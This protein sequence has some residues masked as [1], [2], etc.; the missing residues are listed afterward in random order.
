MLEVLRSKHLSLGPRVPAFEREFA[1][2]VG[3][4]HASRGL[5]RHRRA[6]PRAAR[7]GRAA[8]ATRSSRRR[9]ASSRPPT[10]SSTSARSPSSWTSTRAR[11]TSTS[12]PRRPRSPNDHRAAA[13]PHLRLPGRHARAGAARAADRR[14][15]LRGARR[16]VTPTASPSAAA[17]TPRRSAST[18]TSSSSPARAGCSRTGSGGDQGARGLRAQPGP[19]ARHGLAGPRPARLQ[20]PADRHGVRD[21]PGPAAA[22]RRHA[23]RPRPGGG[24][25]PR[26]AGRLRGPGAAV[27]GH[28]RTCAAGSCSSSSSRTAPTATRRSWRWRPTRRP[29]QALPARD[30]PDDLLPRDASGTARASSRSARTSPRARSRCRSSRRSPQS[31]IA[32][33]AEALESVLYTAIR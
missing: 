24:L 14:G 4:P 10:R 33:V 16:D 28:R 23:R 9:S 2:R 6:A 30:P 25:V 13:G 18:P 32:Q 11:S 15:R 5:E 17:A 3:A 1:A 7:R 29:V 22:P 8:T 20:L 19:R 12:T 27:R 26:G 21:G 31:Q